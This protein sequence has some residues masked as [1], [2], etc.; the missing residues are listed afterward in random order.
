MSTKSKGAT[1]KQQRICGYAIQLCDPLCMFFDEDVYALDDLKFVLR[2]IHL[3]KSDKHSSKL[4]TPSLC[5]R[6]PPNV[7][8]SNKST[9]TKTNK[10][11]FRQWFQKYLYKI[12]PDTIL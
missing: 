6:K 4:K 5:I 2:L 1:Q 7:H 8:C 11:I 10:T 3:C 12:I 9:P